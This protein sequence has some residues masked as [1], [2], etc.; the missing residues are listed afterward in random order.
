MKRTARSNLL[1]VRKGKYSLS[2][3]KD[4]AS[5]APGTVVRARFEWLEMT[6]RDSLFSKE[7]MIHSECQPKALYSL[8]RQPKQVAKVATWWLLE[9]IPGKPKRCLH[10]RLEDRGRS[11]F[12]ECLGLHHFKE[13]L[14]HYGWRVLQS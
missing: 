11:H 12:N 5:R 8:S 6:K 7:L 13:I 1:L 3:T 10:C 2:L 9:K 14:S 4:T